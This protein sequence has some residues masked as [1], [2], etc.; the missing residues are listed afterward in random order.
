MSKLSAA[1]N[2]SSP[3]E[4]V[5]GLEV[6]SSRYDVLLC[7][8]WGVLHNGLAAFPAAGDA[9]V[10]YRA[11]GGRVV[12]VSNAPRPGADVATQLDGLGAP[13]DA[14]DAIVTSGDVTRAAVAARGAE[15]FF[16]LGPKRDLGLF[17]G[18]DA[19]FT[20]LGEAAY[21]VCTG[22]FDDEREAVSDYAGALDTMRRSDLPMICANPDVVVERGDRLIPCAGAIAAAYE[23]IGG[24][25]FTG[26]KPHAP[27][28]EA[29]VARASELLG[30]EPVRSRILAIGDA[31]RTD[32]AGA[33]TFGIDVL[34]I[35]RGIHAAELG[36]AGG[37]SDPRQV[38][39]WLARQP[40]QPTSLAAT[41]IWR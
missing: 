16:H 40:F 41:L 34:M 24:R 14:Y 38:L 35:A 30:R 18:L 28:Y 7:D 4:V 6:L 21:V 33:R 25:V 11:G 39:A 31:I 9:L 17:E 1:P 19:R 15:P 32:I 5:S 10:R 36:M 23:A 22:L 8:I 13:R 37:L 26:G 20:D 27:I 12:L 3:I 29:A 2:H